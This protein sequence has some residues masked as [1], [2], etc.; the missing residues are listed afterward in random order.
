MRTINESD[1]KQ[2]LTAI[3]GY[4]YKVP[5]FQKEIIHTCCDSIINNT[6]YGNISSLDKIILNCTDYENKTKT[7]LIRHYTN[8]LDGEIDFRNPNYDNSTFFERI[9]YDYAE[10]SLSTAMLIWMFGV[11]GFSFLIGFI[12]KLLYHFGILRSYFEKKIMKSA[13]AMAKDVGKIR[14]KYVFRKCPENNILEIPLFKN[15]YMDYKATKEFSDYLQY[16]RVRE[17]PF[18]HLKTRKTLGSKKRWA[19]NDYLFNCKFYFS[20]TPK[21]GKLEVR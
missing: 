21:K 16:I 8:N 12:S 4:W 2:T 19:R 9:K 5:R 14:N 17:H 15:Q 10:Q 18:M 20:Q 6:E 7:F 1:I 13:E 3:D 11:I